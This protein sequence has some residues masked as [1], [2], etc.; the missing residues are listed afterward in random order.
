MRTRPYPRRGLVRFAATLLVLCAAGPAAGQRTSLLELDLHSGR[1]RAF[2]REGAPTAADN[3]LDALLDEGEEQ[4]FSSAD[5]E[6][7][8]RALRRY[9]DGSRPRARARML[10]FV[11]P[12]RISR[13]R[14]AE[15]HEI[16]VDI[17]LV[18]DPCGR[19]VCD[20]SVAVQ[21]ELLGRALRQAVLRSRRFEV[22]FLSVTFRVRSDLRDAPVQVLRFR[23]E[24][25][26][27]AGKAGGGGA[28]LLAQL[29]KAEVGYEAEMT[30]Q[31]AQR[32]RLMRVGLVGAPVVLRGRAGVAVSMKI[33]ADRVRVQQQV[34]TALRAAAAALQRSPHTPASV[35]LEVQAQTSVRGQG[36]RV[37]RCPG[38]PLRL[39]Q[40]GRISQQE[41]WSTY[42]VEQKKGGRHLTFS[43]EDDAGAPGGGEP[44]AD[45]EQVVEMLSARMGELSPCLRAAAARDRRVSRV[46]MSFS[47]NRA[48]RAEGLQLKGRP[49]G[50]EPLRR[51]LQ[52]A[53]QRIRFPAHAGAPQQ[54]DYQMYLQR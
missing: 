16:K 10:L 21:L 32:A 6:G 13:S 52:Q 19:A 23:A 42:I 47:V 30:A 49:G 44:Q 26:V 46:T 28:R 45:A 51:C 43:D 8:A 25:V 17:E 15:L 24:D 40:D 33:Q 18:V 27:Q 35:Q 31:I 14:L 5:L 9:I 22:R 36:T 53:L 37:F 29:K 41:L 38:H 7:I 11:Y 34:L 20:A 3:A 2:D 1:Q 4:G 12:G 54:V 50:G 39:L 48:G